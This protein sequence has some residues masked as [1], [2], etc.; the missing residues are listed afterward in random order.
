MG[1]YDSTPHENLENCPNE[2]ITAGLSTKLYYIPTEFV[3]TFTKPTVGATLAGNMKIPAAGIVL[4]DNKYWKVIDIQLD[5]NELKMNLTRNRGNKKSKTELDFMIP[6]FKANGLGFV[7]TYKNTP[8]LYAIK[9]AEGKLFVIGNKD[10]GGF[11]DTADAT[12]G[13]KIEDNSGISVKII[14]NCKLY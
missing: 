6:G 8:C 13:K 10:I 9:D 1:C 12:T 14:A 5:E 7:E 3:K 2:D 4:K 11:I